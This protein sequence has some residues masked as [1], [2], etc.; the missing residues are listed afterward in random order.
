M[1]AAWFVDRSRGRELS[2][3]RGRQIATLFLPALLFGVAELIGANAFIAAF[4]GGLVFGAASTTLAEER[5][6]GDLLETSADLLGFVV[7]FFFGGLLL[8]VFAGGLKWQWLVIAVLA[9]T[10]LRVI[11]VALAMLGRDSRG[12]RWLSS[13]GSGHGPRHDRVRVAG[14]GGTRSE[15]TVHR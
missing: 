5:D 15:F 2:S 14:T 8:L 13:A 11:P 12:A 10:L 7:W 6:T 4:V 9:L 1:A 3:R